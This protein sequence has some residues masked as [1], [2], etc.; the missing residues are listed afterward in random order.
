M[1]F[2]AFSV[3]QPGLSCERIIAFMCLQQQQVEIRR[4]KHGSWRLKLRKEI[5]SAWPGTCDMVMS[6]GSTPRA[7]PWSTCMHYVIRQESYSN[8]NVAEVSRL[9]FSF[10]ETSKLPK[11]EARVYGNFH[12]FI[13]NFSKSSVLSF[14]TFIIILFYS[15]ILG[16]QRE[17][18][19]TYCLG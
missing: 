15:L 3:F 17:R 5:R 12:I 10:V 4:C 8:Q 7:P 18:E 13:F 6:S 19:K 14:I 1:H 9:F 11:K 2:S 16:T